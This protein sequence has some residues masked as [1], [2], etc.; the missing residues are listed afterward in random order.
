MR[1]TAEVGG[2]RRTVEVRMREGRYTVILDGRPLDLDMQRTGA[3]FLSLLVAGRSHSVGLEKTAA[4]Y[5][6]RVSGQAIDVA[7]FE[8]ASAAASA[9]AASG[10]ARVT[11]PMPGKIVR[12]LVEEGQEVEAGAPLVVIE[13]MK[14][15]NELRA[16]RGGR[17]EKLGARAGQAVEGGALLVELT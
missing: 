16:P 4:G 5:M 14:M 1:L 15:E 10:A 6:V 11:A 2:R 17:V 12:V 7:L 3:G 13:A 9:H 8:G